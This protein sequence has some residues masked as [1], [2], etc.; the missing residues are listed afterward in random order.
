V[1]VD[2][3]EPNTGFVAGLLREAQVWI[4]VASLAFLG[5][6]I[7]KYSGLLS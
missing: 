1:T 3:K 7:I 2:D 6:V 4:V 5:Y